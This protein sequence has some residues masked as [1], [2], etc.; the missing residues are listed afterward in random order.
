MA[1]ILLA[2]APRSGTTWL[3][4]ALGRCRD[5]RYVDEPDGFRTAFAFRVMRQVGENP[6]LAS[7]ADAPDYERLWAGAFAGGAAPSGVGGRVAE[8]AYRR[9]GTDA[10]RRARAGGGTAVGLRVATALARPAVADRVTANVVVKS[11]QCCRSIEWLVDR[12]APVTI[13]VARDP[14]NAIASWRD[15]DFARHPSERVP[16]DE[17]ARRHWGVEPP[18]SGA[19]LLAQQAYVYAV[20]AA[21]FADAARRHP[22]WVTVRHEQLCVD[23]AR[24]LRALAESV[25]LEWTDA[26]EAFVLESDR[27]GTGFATSRVAAD[28]R[29]R[30]RERL[31][32]EDLRVIEPVLAAFPSGL[33]DAS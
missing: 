3:G 22:D 14:L 13:V 7:G 1:R 28:Q 4:Q 21:T 31:T 17:D 11:V 29:D 16:L 18:P 26:A 15:L 20:V 6:R 27:A 10:R 9:A 25:G 2:G 30:W 12:F 23:P 32:A 19:P 5:V 24:S 33:L 8:R